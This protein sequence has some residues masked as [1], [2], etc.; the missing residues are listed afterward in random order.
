MDRFVQ[1]PVAPGNYSDLTAAG[2]KLHW[3]KAPNRGMMPYGEGDPEEDHAAELQTYDIEKEKLSTV[4]AGVK[5]YALSLDRK[6]LVY[7]TKDGFTRLEAGATAA[8]KD[9]EAKEAKIDLSGWSLSV[10]PRQEWKQMLHEAW[11]L[12]RDFFYDPNMHGVDWEGVWKQYGSLA[13]RIASRGD[14]A[15]CLGEMFGELNVSHAYHGGGDIRSGKRIGTGLLAADL[16]YDPATGFWQIQKIYRGDF[17]M[18]NWTSPLARPD[19]RISPGQWLVAIDGKPLV[20]GED[21]LKRLANRAGQEV[22]L[23]INDTPSLDKARRIIV[24]TVGDDTRVRYADWVRENREY[25]DR[26]SNG[27]I[28]YIHLYDMQGRGLRQ[29]ARDYPPQWR[30]RGLIMDDRWNHGGFVAPMILAH[31][32]RKI[33]A[34]TGTRYGNVDTEPPRAFSGYMAALINRQGGSDCETFALGFKQFKLG[35]VIGTRTWGGW[36]GIRG[37]KPLRDGGMLTQPEFGGWDPKGTAWIIEGHGVDPDVELDLEPDGL[38]HGKDVQLDYAIDYL[39][40][41]IAKEPRDL[42]PAPPIQPR[43]LRPVQ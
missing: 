38:L 23:S 13:D 8:P 3:L 26:K 9:D 29:F 35:P 6:V 25:V 32:D 20:K 40:K 31:L 30:K 42:R 34:V 4:T 7:Q 36:V 28:G 14:L 2:D 19:L 41:Q 15:D 27:Q 18:P 5:D 21:Y 24:K 37:D 22:E 16:R 33:L 12:Q 10:N 17:P 39:L 1:V 43:P 11:R